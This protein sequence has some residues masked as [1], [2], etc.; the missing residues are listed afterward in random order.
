MIRFPSFDDRLIS[1]LLY[2]PPGTK[3]KQPVPVIVSIH[4]GPESQYR[5][6][7]SARIQYYVGRLGCAVI[8]PNVRGST[9]YGKTFVNLDNG[10]KREDSVRDIGALL[11]WI[12]ARRELDDRRVAVIGRSYGGYMVLASLVHFGDRLCAGI[13]AAG[14]ANF[15]SFL[16]HTESYRRARRRVEYGD[17]RE[18]DMRAFFDRINLVQNADRIHTPL[19]VVHGVNDPR[20]P[21]AESRRIVNRLQALDRNVWAIYVGDEGH[22]FRKRTNTDFIRVVEVMFLHRHLA[23]NSTE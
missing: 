8:C 20:V 23:L 5:P 3:A 16:E 18:E 10:T 13:E 1:A 4:G 19:L 6:I 14:I 17:E 15:A 7:F 22:R 11:D 12:S 2:R 9:G 21:F